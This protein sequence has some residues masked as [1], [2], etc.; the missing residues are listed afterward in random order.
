MMFVTISVDF[1]LPNFSH[2]QL[3]PLYSCLKGAV[4]EQHLG[5]FSGGKHTS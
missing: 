4:L 2:L 3:S 5:A 1:C